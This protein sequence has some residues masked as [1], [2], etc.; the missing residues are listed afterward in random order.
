MP[1]G[2]SRGLCTAAGSRGARRRESQV[3]RRI[4]AAHAQRPEFKR[5]PPG[6][7][8][9]SH[10][11]RKR[12]MLRCQ[13][14]SVATFASALEDGLCARGAKNRCA[15]FH[16]YA[17]HPDGA[18]A[19][20]R[21]RLHTPDA[22]PH[23]TRPNTSMTTTQAQSRKS[24]RQRIPAQLAIKERGLL[25]LT[26]PAFV[27][28]RPALASSYPRL[29][30]ILHTPS[31]CEHLARFAVISISLHRRGSLACR[32]RAVRRLSGLLRHRLFERLFAP[33]PCAHVAK[34]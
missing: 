30:N 10:F 14:R 15:F 33:H 28:R 21:G 31:S 9:F 29:R 20:S 13:L 8:K 7:C 12:L 23:S 16:H 17:T 2:V 24:C 34:S 27:P 1:V 5:R 22:P 26:D 4:R 25:T 19:G 32:Y 3:G 6:C 18:R 11:S